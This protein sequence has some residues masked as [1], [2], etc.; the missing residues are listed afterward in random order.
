MHKIIQSED[1]MAEEKE[2]VHV[3]KALDFLSRFQY[4]Q[5]RKHQQSNGLGNHIDLLT[6]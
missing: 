4:S 1:R 2:E 5:A 6:R 3:R